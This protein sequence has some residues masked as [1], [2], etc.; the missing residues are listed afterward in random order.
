MGK[1]HITIHDL[2][3]ILNLNASTVS[4]ALNDHPKIS[5]ETKKQVQKLAS[6]MNYQPNALASSLRKGSAHTVGLVLPRVN[7]NF[8]ASAIEGIEAVLN[9][10]GYHLIITQSNENAEK[11]KECISSLI[12]SRVDGIIISISWETKDLSHLIAAQNKKIPLIFFDRIP[13]D[14][15]ASKVMLNDYQGAYQATEYLINNGNKNIAFLAG[16]QHLQIYSERFRGYKTALEDYKY[17]VDP[18]YIIENCLTQEK[19]AEAAA[20][21]L[22]LEKRPDAI[23]GSSDYSALG[24]LVYCKENGLRIPE[25]ISIFGFA[26]EPFTKLIDPPLSSIE[27]FPYKMGESAA[28][29]FLNA[30]NDKSS[31]PQTIEMIPEIRVRQS[32]LSRKVSQF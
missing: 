2:A 32:V 30:V 15:E 13:R 9:K 23:F 3:K 11:E 20:Q 10:A 16:P 12:S 22:S 28:Q 24:A 1:Q 17:P 5:A 14:F 19:G 8:F 29:L 4:R 21:L 31:K 26:N 7:R 6:E 25:D 18:A 27:Q